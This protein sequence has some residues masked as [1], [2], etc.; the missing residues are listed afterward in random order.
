[1]EQLSWSLIGK[2]LVVVADRLWEHI[3]AVGLMVVVNAVNADMVKHDVE[4]ETVDKCVD[5]IGKLAELTDEMQLK[6]EDQ[7]CVYASNE[8]QLHVVGMCLITHTFYL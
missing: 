7:G 4:I 5:E 3:P 6:Q 8:L 1:M 2:T